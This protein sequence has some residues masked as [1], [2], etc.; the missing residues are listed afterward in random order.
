MSARTREFSSPEDPSARLQ[1]SLNIS[2]RIEELSDA[3]DSEYEDMG[4][5]T[6]QE[7]ANIAYINR[8]TIP[9]V[10]DLMTATSKL[11]DKTLTE[12]LPFLEGNPNEFSLNSFGLPQLQREKHIA[13]LED[14]FTDYPEAFLPLDAARPWLVYWGLQGWTALGQDT[15]PY[16]KG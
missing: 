3:T 9:I 16:Q 1:E 12:I 14:V 13:Y 15:A 11:Q 2:N 8:M 6:A 7:E 10:E 5:A 4:V